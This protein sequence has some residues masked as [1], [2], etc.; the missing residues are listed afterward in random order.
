MRGMAIGAHSRHD[1]AAFQ[2]PLGMDTQGVL[3]RHPGFT[4]IG[5]AYGRNPAG[6]VA[7]VAQLGHIARI[8]RRQRIAAPLDIMA[9][10]QSMQIGASGSPRSARRP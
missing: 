5:S 9:A 6:K 8:G 7:L 1:Q 2:K 3:V 10:V 4:P